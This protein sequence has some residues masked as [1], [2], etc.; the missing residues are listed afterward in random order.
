M[1]FYFKTERNFRSGKR[2]GDEGNNKRREGGG[3]LKKWRA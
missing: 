3:E 2:G 1:V